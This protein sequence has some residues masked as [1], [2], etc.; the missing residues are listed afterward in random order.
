LIRLPQERTVA[1]VLGEDLSAVVGE[2]AVVV[3]GTGGAAQVVGELREAVR[4]IVL[5]DGIGVMP[6][7]AKLAPIETKRDSS[8]LRP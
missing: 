1:V 4:K 5:V 8:I 6:S 2:V 3:V 7:G